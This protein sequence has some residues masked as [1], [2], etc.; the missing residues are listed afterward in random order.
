M[1]MISFLCESGRSFALAS[2]T[3]QS[4]AHVQNEQS[5]FDGWGL[6]RRMECGA[7]GY[8]LRVQEC[9]GMMEMDGRLWSGGMN[10]CLLL[11]GLR[12]LRHNNIFYT[13]NELHGE[14]ELRARQTIY[15]Q[16]FIVA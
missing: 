3:L 9:V 8:W 16:S 13:T 6:R 2:Y 11:V 4:P 7:A 5:E 14:A 15:E 12:W 10:D 1:K